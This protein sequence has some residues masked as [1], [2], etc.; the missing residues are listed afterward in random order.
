MSPLCG[1]DAVTAVADKKNPRY[2]VSLFL[3]S[4]FT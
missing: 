1:N 3:C 2:E 4:I